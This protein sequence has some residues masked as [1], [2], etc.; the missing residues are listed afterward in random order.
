MNR[1][2]SGF[3]LVEVVLALGVLAFSILAI[4]GII[5]A[6]LNSSRSSQD[7]TR[8]A[9]LAQ[10]VFASLASGAPS[11]FANVPVTAADGIEP[12]ILT[13]SEVHTLYG[14]NDGRLTRAD[15]A[16]VYRITVKT[17]NAPVGFDPDSANQVT[18]QVAWPASAVAASQTKREY[19]R[20]IS[21]F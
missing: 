18:V 12:F 6:G 10:M 1:R 7:E 13:L 14:G 5:P 3:S 19:I 16:A 20:I 9:Q 4:M 15:T 8:A 17:D 21:R 2:P 11:N